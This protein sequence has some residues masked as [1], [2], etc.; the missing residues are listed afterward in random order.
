MIPSFKSAATCELN[1]TDMMQIGYIKTK[2]AL[3]KVR[4]LIEHEPLILVDLEGD[5]L[6]PRGTIT[7]IQINT[8][9]TAQCFLID[10]LEIGDEE[11]KRPDGWIRYVFYQVLK[12]M[13]RCEKLRPYKYSYYVPL[14]FVL[15]KNSKISL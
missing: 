1:E 5:Q 9:R 2:R 15:K 11:L 14:E 7:L 6:G 13:C 10:I 12:K 4:P 8:Y 3:E